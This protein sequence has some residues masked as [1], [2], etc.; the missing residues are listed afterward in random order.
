[1]SAINGADHRLKLPVCGES[2]DQVLLLGVDPVDLLAAL[3]S[4]RCPGNQRAFWGNQRWDA[5]RTYPN[6]GGS[7]FRFYPDRNEVPFG[8]NL[9][10]EETWTVPHL[11]FSA[12]IWGFL[13]SLPLVSFPSCLHRGL[14]RSFPLPY[15]TSFR[16]PNLLTCLKIVNCSF[17]RSCLYDEAC[18]EVLSGMRG[19]IW[20]T[21]RDRL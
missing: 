14:V 20:Q 9:R 7:V 2:V 10:S 5:L 3:P 19:P 16:M 1:M 6:T 17:F 8:E 12:S 15:K 11:Q 13:F 18:R 4:C 21:R